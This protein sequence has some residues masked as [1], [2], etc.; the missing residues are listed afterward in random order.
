MMNNITYDEKIAFSEVYDIIMYLDIKERNKIPNKFIKFIKANK[1]KNHITKINPYIPLEFQNLSKKTQDIIAYI[2]V[3]YLIDENEKNF[4]KAK[5]KKEIEEEKRSLENTYNIMF[6]RNKEAENTFSKPII[7]E[8]KL[9][10]TIK[11]K[12][13][14]KNLLVL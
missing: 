8:D 10:I 11:N 3:R 12:T 13:N 9:P 5:E 14:L 6:K 4:F 2:Y 7:E 1:L